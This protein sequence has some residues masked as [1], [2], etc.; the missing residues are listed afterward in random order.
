[1]SAGN[2]WIGVVCLEA[3]LDGRL[4]G[5]YIYIHIYIYIFSFSWHCLMQP[6]PGELVSSLSHPFRLSP[7]RPQQ[8]LSKSNARGPL[9]GLFRRKWP[10]LPHSL[11]SPSAFEQPRLTVASL[12][13]FK[14]HQ[15]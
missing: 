4:A 11:K 15:N 5:I 10:I 8:T 9:A 1:M 2:I 14:P 13:F 6:V 7:D 3:A 12:L